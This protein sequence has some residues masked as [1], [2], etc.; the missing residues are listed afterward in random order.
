[1]TAH[2]KL[3]LKT[4]A[5]WRIPSGDALLPRN[6]LP[7]GFNPGDSPRL[8]REGSAGRP[9][10][11]HHRATPS[12]RGRTAERQ[13]ARRGGRRPGRPGP[14]AAPRPCACPRRRAPTATRGPARW[15]TPLALMLLSYLPVAGR[16]RLPATTDK[17][18]TANRL[19][20]GKVTALAGL[21]IG[22]G[23]AACYY[24]LI[25][26]EAGGGLQSNREKV[27]E[28]VIKS[29][30][31]QLSVPGPWLWHWMQMIWSSILVEIQEGFW[32][33]SVRHKGNSRLFANNAALYFEA[34]CT[35]FFLPVLR[36]WSPLIKN[37]SFSPH[38]H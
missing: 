3:I 25:W 11:E 35:S 26:S 16:W 5:A 22:S 31:R 17:A 21:G 19:R 29:C 30:Q 32:H 10:P 12:A 15:Q 4:G 14:A 2:V 7:V 18:D 20:L 1:M 33:G 13:P 28:K 24:C 8:P 27:L 36:V 38:S 6:K 37:I 23:A 9:P 34:F